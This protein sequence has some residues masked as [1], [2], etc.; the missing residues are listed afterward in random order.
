MAWAPSLTGCPGRPQGFILSDPCKIISGEIPVNEMT[1]MDRD[2]IGK[3]ILVVKVVRIFG[4]LL[5]D[6]FEGISC[7]FS[8]LIKVIHPMI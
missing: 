4:G 7:K 3:A 6:L 5:D 1:K 8:A 2:I